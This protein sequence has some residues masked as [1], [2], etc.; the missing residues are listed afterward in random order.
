M[1]QNLLRYYRRMTIELLEDYKSFFQGTVYMGKE[2]KLSTQEG[3]LAVNEAI[4]AL[5]EKSDE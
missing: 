3:I 4:E 1:A 5:K 2:T